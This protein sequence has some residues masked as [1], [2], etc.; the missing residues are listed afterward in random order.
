[1]DRI[2]TYFLRILRPVDWLVAGYQLAMVIVAIV[3][4]S[5][6]DSWTVI[7]ARH[8]LAFFVVITIRGLADRYP[9]R[10]LTALS[11]WYLGLTLPLAYTWAGHFVHAI[12]P[13][14]LD[15]ILHAIDLKL[16]GTDPTLF[17]Q[18]LSR[19]WLTDIMQLSYCSYF[20]IIFFGYLIL[21]L[22]GNRR[23][24][25]NYEFMVIASLY[26]TYIWFMLLPAH[27]PRFITCPEL[28]LQG[29]WITER[30]NH[31]LS[32]AAYAGGAFPSGHAAVSISICV[33]IWRYAR[34][35]AP[36][37]ILLTLL[38]LTS[39]VYGGYHYVVD[40]LAG[41]VHGGLASLTVVLWNRKWRQRGWL[42]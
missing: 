9:S 32:R 38:L 26:G 28:A 5:N 34:P 36:L 24:Y 21:Y 37:F 1:M 3:F 19:P 40:L 35:W 10:F 33:F 12:F 42:K 29:G 39:T 25:Q 16:L 4:R 20:F 18:R 27:S 15:A 23:H 13:W 2:R 30:I 31:F 17:L 6:L 41:M 14:K 22:Q 8:L 7:A 11:E